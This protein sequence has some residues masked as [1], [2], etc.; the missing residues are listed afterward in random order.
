MGG[1]GNVVLSGEMRQG[2]RH[3]LKG[4]PPY[5][6]VIGNASATR[7]TVDGQVFNIMGRSRGNVARFSFDPADLR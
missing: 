7:M 5:M 3:V 1:D 2:D 6:F 4:R